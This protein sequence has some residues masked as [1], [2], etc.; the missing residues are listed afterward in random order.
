MVGGGQKKNLK[1]IQFGEKAKTGEL[2][3]MLQGIFNAVFTIFGKALGRFTVGEF[4]IE[5]AAHFAEQA[6]LGAK[7]GAVTAH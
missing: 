7:T 1:G 6:Q 3:L 2:F 4:Y 5:L